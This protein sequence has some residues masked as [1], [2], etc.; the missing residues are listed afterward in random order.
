MK[1]LLT[2]A[3]VVLLVGCTNQQYY[4]GI[5]VNRRNECLKLPIPQ[6]EECFARYNMSYD[7]YERERQALED[8]LANNNK[9]E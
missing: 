2:I 1:Q 9:K 3:L 5:Q 7:Q 6:R 4:E 8:Q